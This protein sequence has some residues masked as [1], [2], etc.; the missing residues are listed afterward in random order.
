M[1]PNW[2]QSS[3]IN[4]IG[5]VYTILDYSDRFLES[6]TKNALEY[7]CLHEAWK[8]ASDTISCQ[9]NFIMSAIFVVFFAYLPNN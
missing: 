9:N 3:T 6:G 1:T 5:L 8:T 4:D 2:V 7:E